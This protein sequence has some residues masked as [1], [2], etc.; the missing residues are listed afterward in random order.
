[1]QTPHLLLA[2]IALALA[3][4]ASAADEAPLGRDV[5]GLLAHARSHNP[6][7]VAMRMEAEAA[8]ERIGPAGALPD[9]VLRTELENVTNFGSNASPNLLPAR[10]GSTKYTLMQS[11][12]WWG[13]RDLRRD[14]AVA[15]ADESRARATGSW[16]DV[17]ARIK[18]AYAQYY[19]LSR[20]LQYGREVLDL[21]ERLAGIAQVRYAGGLAPQQDAIRAQVERTAIQSELIAMETERH[22]A[23]IRLNT[24]LA[25]G[26]DAPLVPPEMLRPVPPRFD[27]AALT[28]R[29]R[30][31]NPELFAE[32]AR[33]RGA[34]RSRDLTYRNRY[35][36]V[37]LGVAPMQVGTQVN[38]WGVMVELNIPLQQSSRRGQER[39]ADKSVEAAQARKTAAANRLVAELS[40]AVAILEGARRVEGLTATSLLPQ[41]EVTLQAALAGYENGKVDFA[42]ALDAQR[43]I[44]RARQELV[45]AQTE[46]RMRLADIERLIGDEL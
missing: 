31:N 18:V 17:A 29:L 45:K 26:A 20:N 1:M 33:I 37:T 44:R 2:A 23:M 35:P 4:V 36:D 8:A 34:E 22:H 24:A 41:A 46:Q 12:P 13:K 9:P 15:A 7:W 42:S 10:V 19:Q 25:R 43:Q 32:D 3:G 39:E 6:D 40:E 16:V 21:I 11:L 38:Q 28:A 27:V 14:V 30:D 5:D